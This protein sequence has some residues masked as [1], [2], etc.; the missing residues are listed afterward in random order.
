MKSKPRLKAMTDHMDTVRTAV[1]EVVLAASGL[2][3]VIAGHCDLIEGMLPGAA[4]SL[5]KV[6]AKYSAELEE[7]RQ[8]IY[9]L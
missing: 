2:E 7:A 9:E 5:R 6:A 4:A 3:G 8:K 1:H